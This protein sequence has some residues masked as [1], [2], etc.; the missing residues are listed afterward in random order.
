M[1]I[2]VHGTPFTR[3]SLLAFAGRWL[4]AGSDSRRR[5]RARVRPARRAVGTGLPHSAEASGRRVCSSCPPGRTELRPV[6]CRSRR[7]P[8]AS[9]AGAARHLGGLPPSGH[10]ESLSAARSTPCRAAGPVTA[11]YVRRPRTG[12]FRRAGRRF[13]P[14]RA[15]VGLVLLACAGLPVLPAQA[16][17]VTLVSNIGQT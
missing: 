16:Q 17:T 14:W 6:G 9:L 13:A 2:S 1:G 10:P 7:P 3:R 12:F 15:L 11:T 8:E 5:L 4:A